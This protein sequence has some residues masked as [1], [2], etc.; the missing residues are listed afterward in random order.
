M[1]AF[2]E[3]SVVPVREGSMAGEIAKAI[4]ALEAFDVDYETTPMGTVLEAEDASELF[5]AAAAAH[6]A[7]DDDRVITTLEVDDK[8][9]FDQ[10][11]EEKVAAVEDRLGREARRRR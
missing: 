5:V 4:D 1:T 8:R 7:V 10:R 11:A 2:G 9:N 6:D 3:L